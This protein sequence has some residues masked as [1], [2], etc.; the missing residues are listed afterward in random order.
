MCLISLSPNVIRA[1]RNTRCASETRLNQHCIHKAGNI[2]TVVL[3]QKKAKRPS[4]LR[5][6]AKG[7]KANLLLG[8]RW[9]SEHWLFE[10]IERVCVISTALGACFRNAAVSRWSTW[11]RAGSCAMPQHQHEIPHCLS[12][13]ELFHLILDSQK[14]RHCAVKACPQHTPLL[15]LS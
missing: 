1:G 11:H 2:Q 7:E 4:A 9:P 8:W 6:A 13:Q 5:L 12:Q 3:L 15:T 14:F 10:E